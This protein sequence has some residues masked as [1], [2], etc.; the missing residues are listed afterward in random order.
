MSSAATLLLI[1]RA[2][3]T[4]SAVITFV[5]ASQTVSRVIAQRIAEGREWTDDEKALVQADLD[6]AKAYAADQIERGS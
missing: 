6:A 4:L 1:D 2:I 3:G 5:G